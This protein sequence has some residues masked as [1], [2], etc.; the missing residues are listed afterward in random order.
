[1]RTRIKPNLLSLAVASAL[2]SATAVQ[3]EKLLLEEVVVTAVPGGAS[4]LEASVSVSSLGAE[5]VAYTASRSTAEIF[6]ALPGIRSESSGGGGNANITVRGIPL[7][8]GGSKFMQIQEDG[9]PVLEF[10]D[11]NFG[12]TDNFIRF[13]SSVGRIESIRGG[14]ASTFA[15]NS[16]GGVINMISNT[17]EEEG[18]SFGVSMG[19]DYDEF[20]TDFAYGGPISDSLRF[21]VAGFF[22]DGEGVRETGYNGESGGQ[23][24]ANLTKDFDDGYIR[25][26]FKELNDK[27]TTYLPAPVLVKGNGSFGPVAG[28][29]ASSQTLH[30]PSTTSI[31]TFDSF[32]NPQ[33][34]D[35]TDGIESK[36]SSFGFELSKDVAEGL[37]L[38]NKFRQSD[39]SGGFVSPF[40]DTFGAYGPQGAD[41]M[42]NAICNA[43]LDGDGNA[44]NCSATTVSYADT[45]EAYDGMAFLNL[46]FDTRF[47]DLGNLINDLTLSKDF[48]SGFSAT[49]G[50]YY[51][52]Q[53]IATSWASWPAYIQSVDGSNSRYLNIADANGDALVSNGVWT[54]SFLSWEWDLQYTTTAPYFNLGYESDAFSFDASV[55]Q[56]NVKANGELVSTCC[57]GNADYDINGNGV[58][59]SNAEDAS[60]SNGFGF[61]GGVI[62][63]NRSGAGV[64]PVN[65]ES[66]ALSY[67]LGGSFFVSDSTTVFARYSDGVRAVADRLLQISNTLTPTGELT[68]TTDG[69][70]SVQQ[71]EI[72]YKY[73]GD[74]LSL[75]ATFFNTVT[76][77]T[78]AEI[79]SGTTFLR[80][81]E[82]NGI[83]LEG[84]YETDSGFNFRG[85]ITWADAEISSDITNPA[86]EGNTPRR[87]AD[88]IYT[89]T[90]E[91]RNEA[92]AV[93]VTLQG[94][95]D[96]FVSDSN[97]LKQ[98]GYTL[99]HVNASWNISQ[100]L[101]ASL[102]IN[103]L[104]DEF[105]ITE[106][107][108]GSA[109]A[110]DIVRARPISGTSTVASI[111]YRF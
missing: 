28:F 41:S 101:S 33:Q 27:V 77:D 15:S 74:A 2:C 82:A 31:S 109:N 70:D 67:S 9:L 55:R 107:E 90:P 52:K 69:Y 44:F 23:I 40:T 5:D 32:G 60:S 100:D 65:Y 106:S 53:N 73:Q 13:D 111:T 57:G 98:D 80:E 64:Q 17:G 61:G 85:N 91:Y 7:A 95:T 49:F 36:V 24:K 71:L 97:E 34:R 79:T 104:T 75:N 103:N 47:N 48:D 58:I 21:H 81:Y 38:L 35:L 11:I 84:V 50:Y 39:I 54:P 110:G 88:V 37:T 25:F 56:N 30:S 46:L 14:S 12:N 96:Y 26:Y 93:G 3:A 42:A 51:S 99:V 22:R 89:L 105:V 8:T 20:R 87:Q 1:M 108:E 29:D 92:F 72:G 59:D 86:I 4:Q 43:A 45:G 83:E 66:D 76:E 19:V 68:S 63:L 102:N 18:G 16:P 62:N 6:R 94:S 10:G 78:Q